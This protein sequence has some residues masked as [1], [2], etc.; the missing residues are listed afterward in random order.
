MPPSALWEKSEVSAL[1]RAV[2]AVDEAMEKQ[3]R[4]TAIAKHLNTGRSKR[5]CFDK[6]RELKDIRAE[7]K[8]QAA[9]SEASAAAAAEPVPVAEEVAAV[10]ENMEPEPEVPK[11]KV[12]AEVKEVEK[13]EPEP[14]PEPVKEP[15]PEVKEEEPEKEPV[16][17][18]EVKVKAEEPEK[19]DDDDA[20]VEI[21]ELEPKPEPEPEPE[22]AAA[23]DDS[24]VDD[25]FDP[26]YPP[27]TAPLSLDSA[28]GLRALVFGPEAAN[29]FPPSWTKQGF[30]FTSEDDLKF[31]LIQTDGGPCGAIAAV[32]AFVLRQMLF[33][34]AETPAALSGDDWKNPG[35]GD[36]KKAVCTALA[37]IIWNCA[38]SLVGEGEG[39]GKVKKQRA[40]HVCVPSDKAVLTDKKKLKPDGATELMS[41]T[42]CYNYDDVFA[43]LK[44]NLAAFTKKSGAGVIGMAYSCL[45]SRG[46]EQVKADMDENFGMTPKLI[47]NHGYANQ[48]FVNLFLTGMATSNLFDGQK[49]FSDD[50]GSSGDEIVMRGIAGQGDVGFLTLFEAYK[51]LEV[52]PNLKAPKTP[53]WV[54]CSESHYSTLFALDPK[55]NEVAEDATGSTTVYYYDPLGQQDEEIK[56]TLDWDKGKD[57]DLDDVGDENDL[58]PPLDKVVRTKW[59]KVDVDWNGAEKI[60]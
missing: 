47:G 4:W 55:L 29:S 3:A 35:K 26:S 16:K 46:L 15:E 56:L 9:D 41:V 59:G 22:P 10:K 53:V 40:A 12:A 27:T 24:D 36:Q 49:K 39:F 31:G 48:E 58:T 5:E 34:S 23:D 21:P 50:T 51:S 6:Y 17:E 42:T 11:E 54:V 37:H 7:A 30:F 13:P 43:T 8:R 60:L 45:L 1:K 52:G 25:S 14:E 2:R 33:G 18:S 32:Q 19:A 38:T 44:E 20:P 57:I 28:V